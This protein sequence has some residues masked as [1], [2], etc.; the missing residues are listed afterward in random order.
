MLAVLARHWKELGR[1]SKDCSED[2]V[3][4]DSDGRCGRM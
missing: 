3:V 2:D 4:L 1:S